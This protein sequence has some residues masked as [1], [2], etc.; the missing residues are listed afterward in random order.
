MLALLR[1]CRIL[2]PV[3]GTDHRFGQARGPVP[4]IHLG[5]YSTL[6]CFGQARGLFLRFV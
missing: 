3:P 4:T 6:P 5:V 1:F 2:G